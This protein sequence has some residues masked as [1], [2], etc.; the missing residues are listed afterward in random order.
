[1]LEHHNNEVD[2]TEGDM[3]IDDTISLAESDHCESLSESEYKKPR[4]DR[5]FELE[6][7]FTEL[8][9]LYS[10]LETNNPLRVT[11]LTIAPSSWSINKI[12]R[13]FCTSKRM[14]KKG[15]ELKS[16]RSI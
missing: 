3:D 5:E 2:I 11:I 15:K 12:A 10:S 6:Q 13:E 1:M 16:L 4:S 14:A 8:K 9:E 7:V